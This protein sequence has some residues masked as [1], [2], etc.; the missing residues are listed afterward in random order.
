MD[1]PNNYDLTERLDAFEQWT[2]HNVMSA[3]SRRVYKSRLRSFFT[4]LDEAGFDKKSVF[5][6]HDSRRNAID[7]YKNSVRSY[8]KAATINGVMSTVN[9]FF[10]FNGVQAVP[11]DREFCSSISHKTLSAEDQDRLLQ[12]LHK[13]CR[14][15]DRALVL[16]ILAT[17]IKISECAGLNVGDLLL[18]GNTV[19]LKIYTGCGSVESNSMC[20]TKNVVVPN[21]VARI[22]ADWI[23]RREL[24]KSNFAPAL[25]LNRQGL[26][27][28]TASID[29]VVRRVGWASGLVLSAEMLRRTYFMSNMVPAQSNYETLPIVQ[30]HDEPIFSGRFRSEQPGLRD[31]YMS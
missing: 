29:M 7:C 8:L 25:F 9:L 1:F 27:M 28:S 22:L 18:S 4:V 20:K 30:T 6:D 5:V 15:Q 31:H 16:L 13:N 24:D 10:E 26:R 11:V 17:G 21:T 12:V 2:T 3:Q 23:A 14:K 19:S